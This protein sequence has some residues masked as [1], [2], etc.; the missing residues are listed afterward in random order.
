MIPLLNL[1]SLGLEVLG[2]RGGGR[3]VSGED[4]LEEGS[5]NDLGAT[6]TVVSQGSSCINS[7]K[8]HTRSGEEPSR[9]RGRT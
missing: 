9:E 6:I 8:E 1:L 4:W 7:L 2:C 3:E 5:E